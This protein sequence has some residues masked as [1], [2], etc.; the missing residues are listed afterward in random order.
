[1]TFGRHVISTGDEHFVAQTLRT[2]GGPNAGPRA[3]PVVINE[4]LYR[5]ADLADGSDNSD[6]EFIELLNISGGSVSLFD[7]AHSTN[8]WR[9]SGGVDFSFPTG[10]SLASG[11]FALFVNFNPTNATQLA[12][13]RSKYGVGPGI[14]IFG[15]YDGKL[16][17]DG[18][19]VELKKPTT[20]L[21]AGVPYVLVDKVSYRDTAP[22]PGG[23]DG[24]GLSLQRRVAAAYGNDPANWFAAPPTA[25]AGGSSIGNPPILLT[26]PQSQT[27]VAYSSPV[28]GVT[29]GGDG[30]LRYQIGRASCRERV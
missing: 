27:V 10:A 6:D 3:G 2:L 30:P 19:D 9:L 7:P 15:P 4:I 23:A 8:T 14:Q 17:N 26:Q 21:P 18:E 16:A 22:W 12:A 5:P 24:Y 20:P 11:E 13:F 29:A 1:M 28:L 25:A